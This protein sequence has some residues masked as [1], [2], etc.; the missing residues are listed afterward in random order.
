MRRTLNARLFACLLV[1]V[2]VLG[3]GVHYLHAFQVRRTAKGLL[4]QAIEADVPKQ[5]VVPKDVDALARFALALDKKKADRDRIRAL[6]VMKQVLRL[7]ENRNDV[8]RRLIDTLIHLK[9]FDEAAEEIGKLLDA[10]PGDAKQR[11]ELEELRAEI[12]RLK[13]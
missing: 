7:E 13:P 5:A 2:L 9:R 3:V 8:R 4:E 11:A 12:K 1:A 10:D 6:L